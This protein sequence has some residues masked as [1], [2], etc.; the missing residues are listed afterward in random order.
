MDKVNEFH[1]KIGTLKIL[2][3]HPNLTLEWLNFFQKKIGTLK[4]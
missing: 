1:K 4:Y 2:S 3:S